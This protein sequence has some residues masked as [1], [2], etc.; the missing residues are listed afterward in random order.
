MAPNTVYTREES[1]DLYVSV[2]FF[3]P[4]DDLMRTV[5]TLNEGK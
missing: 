4:P 2:A 1:E 3:S 5:G